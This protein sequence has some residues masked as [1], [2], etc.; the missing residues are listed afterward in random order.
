MQGKYTVKRAY[1]AQRVRRWIVSTSLWIGEDSLLQGYKVGGKDM[2]GLLKKDIDTHWKSVVFMLV[3]VAAFVKC[4][5]AA[6]VS[7]VFIGVPCPACGMTRA[8]FLFLTGH[9]LES[10]KMQP[11]FY[12]LLV[13]IVLFVLYRYIIRKEKY[14]KIFYC[15]SMVMLVAAIGFYLYRMIRFFPDVPPMTYSKQNLL[16]YIIHKWL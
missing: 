10:L 4:F 15:Y 14:K 13:G 2:W 6:C 12:A 3:I 16:Y 11:F 1:G 7:R 5:G 8:A 9:W